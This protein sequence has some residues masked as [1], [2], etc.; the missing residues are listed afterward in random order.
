MDLGPNHWMS[1]ELTLGRLS[2]RSA[3]AMPMRIPT[4][5]DKEKSRLDQIKDL[6]DR[7]DDAIFSPK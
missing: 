5:L 1:M 4:G 6:R 7:S 2:G 3:M